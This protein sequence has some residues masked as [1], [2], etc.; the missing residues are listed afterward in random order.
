M[1][2][3]LKWCI[4]P[5]ARWCGAWEKLNKGL[6][7]RDLI[8]IPLTPEN[9][10]QHFRGL[11]WFAEAH[12]IWRRWRWA[13]VIGDVAAI[14]PFCRRWFMR[15]RYSLY[16]CWQGQISLNQQVWM[17]RLL[18]LSMKASEWQPLYAGSLA[19]RS[20]LRQDIILSWPILLPGIPAD[21]AL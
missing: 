16:E 18:V 10:E 5:A 1:V 9:F 8:S 21:G 13:D 14:S 12:L 2:S 4:L 11:S 15:S 3:T 20:M 7:S 6:R 19:R 17:K